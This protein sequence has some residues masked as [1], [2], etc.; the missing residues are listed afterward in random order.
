[1]SNPEDQTSMIIMNNY[2]GIGIDADVCLKFHNKV[3]KTENEMRRS[4]FRTEVC[5]KVRNGS[6]YVK[7]AS[8]IAKKMHNKGHPSS[9]C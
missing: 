4:V 5:S 9:S 7:N 3:R 6:S 2:F 8:A 1:M